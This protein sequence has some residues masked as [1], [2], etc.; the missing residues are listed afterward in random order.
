MLNILCA[1]KKI[2]IC[3]TRKRLLA[4][5]P[6]LVHYISKLSKINAKFNAEIC[7]V[8]AKLFEPTQNSSKFCNFNGGFNNNLSKMCNKFNAQLCRIQALEH[9]IW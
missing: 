5:S 4:D 1:L 9:K 7:K 6:F 3:Y 8:N 2:E